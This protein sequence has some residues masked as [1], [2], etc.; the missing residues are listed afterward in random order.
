MAAARVALREPANAYARNTPYR[1]FTHLSP[2]H[3]AVH[4]QWGSAYGLEPYAVAAD[5]Y[6]AP[7]W[8]GHGGWSWYTGA[9]GW[10]YRA[11]VESLLGL[12]WEAGRLSLTPCLPLHWPQAEITLTRDGRS[13]K[14]ALV[15]VGSQQA[16]TACADPATRWLKVGE[17]LRWT[18]LPLSCRFVLALT[19]SG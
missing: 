2:A 5:V 16:F 11:A 19:P 9:S 13:V 10:L 8:V 1:Y 7:P 4:P 6:S 17:S 12:R 3:R 15:R 14:F 18:D